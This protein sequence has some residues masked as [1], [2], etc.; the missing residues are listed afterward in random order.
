MLPCENSR[1]SSH[2]SA[3]TRGSSPATRC[4]GQWLD[5]NTFPNHVER[6]KASDEKKQKV[7]ARYMILR[8]RNINASFKDGQATRDL[9]DLPPRQYNADHSALERGLNGHAF[10]D[11]GWRGRLV[12]VRQLESGAGKQIAILVAGAFAAAGK[13]QH[14]QIEQLAERGLIAW[15]DDN[16]YDQQPP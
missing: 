4:Q 13:Y 14:F 7:T 6:D 9:L 5:S 15:R 1:L 16:F 10:D 11:A 2:S 12:N 3:S 8:V